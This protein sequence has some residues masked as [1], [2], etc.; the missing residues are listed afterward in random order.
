MFEGIL[1]RKNFPKYGFKENLSIEVAKTPLS[2]ERCQN[3]R[4]RQWRTV[5][6]KEEEVFLTMEPQMV[7]VIFTIM[8]CSLSQGVFGA[9][10]YA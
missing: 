5:V 10:F 2:L 7:D 4:W 3:K 9:R 1:K 8:C 6:Q